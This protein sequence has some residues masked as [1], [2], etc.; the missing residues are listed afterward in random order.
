MPFDLEQTTHIF[1]VIDNGGLQQ[2]IADNPDA[3]EQIALIREHLAEEA[4]RFAVGDFHDPE[5]IHGE[6][7]AG[8]HELVINADKINIEYS[9]LPNGAQ[10]LYTTKH[11]ELITAIHQWLEAQ[12]ADHGDHATDHR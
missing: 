2:V 6:H 12:L 4:E 7:M 10:I 9:E 5:I 1:E 8:M 3:V 11:A